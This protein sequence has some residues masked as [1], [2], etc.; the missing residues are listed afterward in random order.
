MRGLIMDDALLVGVAAR[1]SMAEF[2]YLDEVIY[3]VPW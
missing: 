2:T 1:P 3:V